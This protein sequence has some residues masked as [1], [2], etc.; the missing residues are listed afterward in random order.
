MEKRSKARKWIH[1]H[2]VQQKAAS[3]LLQRFQ[4]KQEQERL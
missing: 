4:Q 3:A 2:D 1:R